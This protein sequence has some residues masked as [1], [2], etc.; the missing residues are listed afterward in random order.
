MKTVGFMAVVQAA[1]IFKCSDFLSGILKVT[2]M[3]KVCHSTNI[4]LG[5][6]L[7]DNFVPSHSFASHGDPKLPN[8]EVQLHSINDKSAWPLEGMNFYYCK[9]ALYGGHKENR[10]IWF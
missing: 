9:V 7:Y 2:N 6:C 3:A 4:L 8:P 10:Y 5:H 1:L